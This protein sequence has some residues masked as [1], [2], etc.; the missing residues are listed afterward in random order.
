MIFLEERRRHT[1]MESRVRN[2]KRK[3]V[4]MNT[5]AI[6]YGMLSLAFLFLMIL[7]SVYIVIQ[8]IKEI[9]K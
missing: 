1:L 9:K 8:I 3:A 7:M 2:T 5:I 6:V 4:K